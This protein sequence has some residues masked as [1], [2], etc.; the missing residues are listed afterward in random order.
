MNLLPNWI[1]TIYVILTNTVTLSC[2]YQE[3]RPLYQRY[4][5]A[6]K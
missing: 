5:N 6:L 4:W 2:H 3:R 1:F